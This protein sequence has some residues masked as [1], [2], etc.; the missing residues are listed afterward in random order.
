MPIKTIDRCAICGQSKADHHKFKPITVVIPDG[1]VCDPIYWLESV[2]EWSEIELLNGEKFM[3][4]P[5]C[6]SFCGSIYQP[7]YC[8][9]CDHQE[10]CHTS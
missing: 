4:P 1:C 2:F 9:D 8:L 10:A 7:S 5:A 3:I 6:N